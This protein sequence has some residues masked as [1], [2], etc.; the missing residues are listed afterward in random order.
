MDNAQDAAIATLTR[1]SKVA[2][3]NGM[4]ARWLE[5]ARARTV[6]PSALVRWERA[7]KAREK[8]VRHG[9]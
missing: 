4:H 9:R 7:E 8:A 5:L 6:S 1:R 3:D 2:N